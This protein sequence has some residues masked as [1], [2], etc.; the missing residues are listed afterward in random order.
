MQQQVNGTPPWFRLQI[1]P[2]F[3]NAVRK[4]KD[5]APTEGRLFENKQPGA[6][7]RYPNGIALSA[8]R[9]FLVVA[10]TPSKRLRRIALSGARAGQA[11]TLLGALPGYPD[12]VSSAPGGGFWIT[13]VSPSQPPWLEK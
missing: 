13:L 4:P 12:G 8:D 11:E 1:R 2:C 9:S 6:W 5:C 10:E 7:R 3:P